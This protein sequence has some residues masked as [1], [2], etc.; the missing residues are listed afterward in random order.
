MQLIDFLTEHAGWLL[1]ISLLTAILTLAL[2]PVLITNIP[3]DYFSCDHRLRISTRHPLIT[4]VIKAAKNLLGA[5]FLLVGFVLLFLPGQGLILILVGMMIMNYPGKYRLE[6]WLV[7]R[8]GVLPA[9]NALRARHGKAPL[10][11]P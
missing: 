10:L 8:R 11:P 2:V 9:L 6:C 4:F 3:A 5:V 7:Q 1:V